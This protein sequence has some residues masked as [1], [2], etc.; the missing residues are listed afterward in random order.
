MQETVREQLRRQ[1]RWLTLGF[2]AI[3]LIGF[4]AVVMTSVNGESVFQ[5]PL[6]ILVTVI[7]VAYVYSVRC[8]CP[9]CGKSVAG[10]YGRVPAACPYCRLDFNAPWP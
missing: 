7:A 10:I 2:V 6:W 9:R 1:V 8:K 4:L 5:S 3:M